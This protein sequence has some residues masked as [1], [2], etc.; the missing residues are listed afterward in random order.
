MTK[1]TT[2]LMPER[3]ML[4]EVMERIIPF[5]RLL[6]VQLV[7]I[8]D[9]A[10]TVHLPFKDDFIGDVTKPAV[11]GGVISALLDLTG[12][13]AVFSQISGGDSISTIDLLVDYLRPCPPGTIVATA[14]VVRMGGRVALAQLTAHIDGDPDHLIA[15][16]R[17]AYNIKR[18]T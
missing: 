3:E 14:K 7:A 13:A 2:S 9:G 5:N 10:V 12:G 16:G 15:T 4:K 18:G 8:D 6:G 1:P 17:A 11:H